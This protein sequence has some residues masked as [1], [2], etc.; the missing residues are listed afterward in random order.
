[1]DRVRESCRHSPADLAELRARHEAHNE[2]V[3]ADALLR[4]PIQQLT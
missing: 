4:E 2:L 3:V 1:M